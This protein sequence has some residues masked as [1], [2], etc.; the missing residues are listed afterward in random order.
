L[1]AFEEIESLDGLDPP[2][3]PGWE[4]CGQMENHLGAAMYEI[5]VWIYANFDFN[6]WMD[7]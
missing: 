1:D 3:E 4:E 5:G 2:M 7:L 6:H